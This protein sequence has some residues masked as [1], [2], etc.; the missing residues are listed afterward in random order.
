ME[1]VELN[2]IAP[3]HTAV[4]RATVP[5]RELPAFL[6]HAFAA[7]ADALARQGVHVTGPP[8]AL[9]RSVPGDTVDVEAG[10]PVAAEVLPEGEV[11]PSSV[12]GG[13]A[14][15][16]VHIGPYETLGDAYCAQ[17]RRTAI[18]PFR[19]DDVGEELGIGLVAEMVPALKDVLR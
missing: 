4:V 16:T 11:R 3:R 5:M 10:F 15:E 12:P 6:S 13:A 8:L 7:V 2:R 18:G 14:I 19:V 9:Y 1:G 17:L